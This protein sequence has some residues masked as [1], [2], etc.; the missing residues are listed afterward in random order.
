MS[1]FSFTLMVLGVIS[2]C[3][4]VNTVTLLLTALQF[5]RTLHRVNAILPDAARAIREGHRSLRR[6]RRLLV[7][8]DRAARPIEAVIRRAGE[9]AAETIERVGLFRDRAEHA[10][11]GRLGNGAGAEPRRYHRSR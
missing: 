9:L 2:V 4:L 11:L 10:L 8:V 1:E 5:R 3:L 7:R 6:V